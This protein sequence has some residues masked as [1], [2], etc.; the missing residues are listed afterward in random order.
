MDFKKEKQWISQQ[1]EDVAEFWLKYGMDK[2]N[3]GVYTCIDKD[4]KVFST[5]KSV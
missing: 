2:V 1:L 3:G 4:G 5:D